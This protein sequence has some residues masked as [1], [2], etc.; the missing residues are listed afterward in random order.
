[1]SI[2]IRWLSLSTL[3]WVL[4]WFQS[5]FCIILSKLATSSMRVKDVSSMRYLES[6]QTHTEGLYLHGDSMAR[7]FLQRDMNY[8]PE[9]NLTKIK[10]ALVFWTN[11]SVMDPVL[12]PRTGFVC[13]YYHE[14]IYRRVPELT[15]LH[16]GFSRLH[17]TTVDTFIPAYKNGP[18][19]FYDI[20]LTKPFY[21]TI[22]DRNVD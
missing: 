15:C 17:L 12:F 5:F 21:I 8:A 19:Y 18:D 3:R 20:S 14:Y 6:T 10:R 22:W 1:M 9:S 16:Y 13:F 4:I 11:K 2:F 7:C